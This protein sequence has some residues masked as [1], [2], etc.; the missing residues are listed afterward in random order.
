MYKIISSLLDPCNYA[1]KLNC[2]RFLTVPTI[3]SINTLLT[4]SVYNQH[5]GGIK[6]IK[7][8]KQMFYLNNSYVEAK[9]MQL[10]DAILQGLELIPLSQFDSFAN[11]ISFCGKFIEAYRLNKNY[12]DGIVSEI[13][14]NTNEKK[15]LILSF[16]EEA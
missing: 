2:L 14:F 4:H 3:D 7:I 16:S 11:S 8:L 1:N 5:C 12:Y 6:E 10:S 9:M 13:A 15:S